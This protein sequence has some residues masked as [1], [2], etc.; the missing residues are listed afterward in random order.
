L[1]VCGPEALRSGDT[2]ARVFKDTSHRV[3]A[4][5]TDGDGLRIQITDTGTAITAG[6]G[7][8]ERRVGIG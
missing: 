8:R 3:S 5:Q 7:T 4:L 6:D 2:L 1:R